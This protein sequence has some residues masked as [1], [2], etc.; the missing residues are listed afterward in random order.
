LK[1]T[2]QM[3]YFFIPID[4]YINP[5]HVES[6]WVIQE[7]LQLSGSAFWLP[8]MEPLVGEVNSWLMNFDYFGMVPSLF[9]SLTLSLVWRPRGNQSLSSIRTFLI[10]VNSIMLNQRWVCPTMGDYPKPAFFSMVNIMIWPWKYV[11][12]PQ[13]NDRTSPFENWWLFVGLYLSLQ[14]E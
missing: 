2:S 11:V 3:I 10:L 12:V 1:T 14:K 6:A 7:T 13:I 4:P 5:D 8:P 9:G